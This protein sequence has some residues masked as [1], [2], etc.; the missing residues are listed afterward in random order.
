MINGAIYEEM[1]HN[2]SFFL[3]VFYKVLAKG[4]LLELVEKIM[5]MFWLKSVRV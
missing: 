3:Q 1:A 5:K 2:F 4:T